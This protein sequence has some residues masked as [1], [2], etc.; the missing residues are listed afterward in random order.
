MISQYNNFIGMYQDVYP[1]GFCNHLINEFE[2]LLQSGVCNNRQAAE[3]TTKTRKEDFHYFMN[4]RSNPMSP[5][6]DICVNEIFITGLQNCFDDY[7]DEFD[8]LK[9]YNLRCTTLKM[10]KTEPGAGYHVWH[11]EQ[12]SDADASRCLVYSAYLNTIEEAG[13]TEFLYQKL[14]VAPK[15]NTVVIWPAAFTHTHR[16]NVV[17]GDKSKY[18]ITGWFYIE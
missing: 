1:D 11:A 16:G 3:N 2:R 4:L 5:F 17:H 10:Q 12:G 9:D 14:R 18:I 6:N 8:I 15:E 7:V 13:E